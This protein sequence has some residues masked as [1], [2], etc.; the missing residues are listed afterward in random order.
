[1]SDRVVNLSE[2]DVEADSLDI[3]EH[4]YWKQDNDDI[5]ALIGLA[6]EVFLLRKLFADMAID[7]DA[8]A[9]AASREREECHRLVMDMAA[10]EE[11]QQDWIARAAILNVAYE[12][13]R[14]K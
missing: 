10:R 6:K 13:L 9:L 1:M 14:R 5:I 2:D 3:I 4:P 8:L 12:L 7:S 11:A